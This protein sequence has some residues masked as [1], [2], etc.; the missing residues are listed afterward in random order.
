VSGI[1]IHVLLVGGF[2][3]V[4]SLA[5]APMESLGWWAG[6]LGPERSAGAV[7]PPAEA[8]AAGPSPKCFLVFL[9]GIGSISGD[10]LLPQESAFLDRLAALLPEVRIVRDVFP[11]APSGRQLLTGQRVF[12][13]LWRRVLAWR[14]NGTRLL[15]AILNLRNLFQV[16]VSADHR[17]GPLYSFGIARVVRER[18]EAHGYAAGS[19]VP[20]VLVG[21][22]GGG[23]ISVGAATY[24]GAEIGADLSIVT[25]GGVMSSDRGIEDVARL[26]SLYGTDDRVYKL[27]RAAFPGRW[28]IAPSSFWNTARTER[29]L[30]ER[31][32]GPMG[33]SGRGGYLDPAPRAGGSYLDLTVTAVAE[34][35]RRELALPAMADPAP[36]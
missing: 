17:Y 14:L 15:P 36:R 21:S 16:L 6:W 19:G 29:R 34:A 1:L 10:E 9:S 18:L 13:W 20:V 25:F 5:M 12:S 31:V 2:A 11:Y 22:S 28:P 4:L 3:L 35:V 23:Q 27:G 30:T 7:H 8:D 32:I 33:H 24:I 26:A